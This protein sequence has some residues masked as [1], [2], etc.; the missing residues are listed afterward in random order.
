MLFMICEAQFFG[1]K[2]NA[3]MLP[4]AFNL[5]AILKTGSFFLHAGRRN[6]SEL[7]APK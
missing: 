5:M 3:S 1:F 6:N 4:Y 2:S 7:R